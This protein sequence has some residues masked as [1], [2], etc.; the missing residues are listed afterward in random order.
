MQVIESAAAEC[1]SPLYRV[2]RDFR[3]HR[4]DDAPFRTPPVR[5]QSAGRDLGEFPL[6]LFGHHQGANAAAVIVA[7][8]RLRAAGIQITDQAV[9]AGLFDVVWPARM[10]LLRRRPVVVLDCAHNVASIHALVETLAESFPIAG[11]RHMILAMSSDKQIPE[12]LAELAPV[13]DAFHLTQYRSNPRSFDPDM[14]RPSCGSSGI[15]S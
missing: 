4:E 15:R 8:E 14:E 2:G 10:E 3:W 11:R 6:R 12:M 1:K 13:I 9:T 5:V 7:V